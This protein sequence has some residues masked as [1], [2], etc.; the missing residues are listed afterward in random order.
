[1][2]NLLL[3]KRPYRPR[4][5]DELID[6]HSQMTCEWGHLDIRGIEQAIKIFCEGRIHLALENLFNGRRVEYSSNTLIA[7]CIAIKANS[8]AIYEWWKDDDKR[9][10]EFLDKYTEWYFN[11]CLKED[12]DSYEAKRV[13]NNPLSDLDDIWKAERKRTLG[14]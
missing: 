12:K 5:L 10:Y 14:Y 11:G 2:E 4:N 9:F 7:A 8:E 13:R 3:V 6:F 1:M